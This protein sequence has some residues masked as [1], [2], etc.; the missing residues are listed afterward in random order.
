MGFVNGQE[1]VKKGSSCLHIPIFHFSG[2]ALPRIFT[3]LGPEFMMFAFIQLVWVNIV[4]CIKKQNKPYT[5]KNIKAEQKTS[6]LT[7]FYQ[8]CLM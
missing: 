2:S 5:Q 3:G 8:V 6:K 1:D 7:I 4:I